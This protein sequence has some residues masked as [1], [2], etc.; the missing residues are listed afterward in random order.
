MKELRQD[1]KKTLTK[2]K[3]ENKEWM[4]AKNVVIMA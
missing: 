4:S 2:K 3:K 1:K